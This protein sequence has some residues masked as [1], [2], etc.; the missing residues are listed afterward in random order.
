MSMSP[1]ETLLETVE[2]PMKV[3]EFIDL[4]ERLRQMHEKT[5]ELAAQQLELTLQLETAFKNARELHQK[6]L[7]E[8][9]ELGG[10]A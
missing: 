8:Q 2:R 10:E 3:A 7:T 5:S 9:N 1:P 4:M 6:M